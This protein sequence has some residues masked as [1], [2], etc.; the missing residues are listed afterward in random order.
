MKFTTLFAAFAATLVSAAPSEVD[1]VKRDV[2]NPH[3]LYPNHQ[4]TWKAGT[5]YE[6]IWYVLRLLES[7]FSN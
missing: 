2:W 3:I 1:F 5:T 4:T 6:V 7:F